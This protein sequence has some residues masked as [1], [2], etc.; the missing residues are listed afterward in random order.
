GSPPSR[1]V[2]ASLSALSDKYPCFE[3]QLGESHVASIG[4]TFLEENCHVSIQTQNSGR[5]AA[6]RRP[7]GGHAIFDDAW[8]SCTGGL[9][10]RASQYR[11]RLGRNRRSDHHAASW[12]SAATRRDGGGT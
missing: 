3:S 5:P 7:R 4:R 8:A 6:R 2:H 9:A 11:R 1:R 10:D 12:S